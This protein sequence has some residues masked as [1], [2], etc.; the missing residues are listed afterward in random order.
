MIAFGNAVLHRGYEGALGELRAHQLST[1]ALLVLLAPWVLRTERRHPLPTRSAAA[2]VG[3]CWAAATVV[4]EF[5]FG[6][7]VNRDSWATLLHDYDL[8]A[9]R[10]WLFDIVGIALLPALAR[11]WRLHRNG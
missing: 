4:F 6:H 8:R 3:L 9:G 7:Y 11:A 5:G 2:Q 10:L 1:A